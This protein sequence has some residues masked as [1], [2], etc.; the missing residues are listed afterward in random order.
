MNK[1]VRILDV[2]DGLVAPPVAIRHTISVLSN[3]HV[4]G[5]YDLIPMITLD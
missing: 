2:Y 1:A 4:I 3:G 5:Q